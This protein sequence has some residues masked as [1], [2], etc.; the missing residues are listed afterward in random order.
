[1]GSMVR[2]NI[3]RVVNKGG[4][5]SFNKVLEVALNKDTMD[6]VGKELVTMTKK[7]LKQGI[8]TDGNVVGKLPPLSPDWIARRKVLA[9][10][11]QTAPWFKPAKSNITLT[12]QLIESVKYDTWKNVVKIDFSNESR[13]P[14]T[15]KNGSKGKSISNKKLAGFLAERHGSLIG[16]TEP[17]RNRVIKIVERRLRALLRAFR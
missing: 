14:Y 13:V 12:G 1:M 6:E 10:H 11:N 7:N 4:S 15:N 3:S 9:M 16:L 2:V 8:I 5:K 17:M